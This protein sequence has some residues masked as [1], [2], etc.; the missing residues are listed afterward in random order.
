[1]AVPHL[2]FE[3]AGGF[4]H[5]HRPCVPGPYASPGASGGAPVDV[6]ASLDGIGGGLLSEDAAHVVEQPEDTSG[7]RRWM[8]ARCVCVCWWCAASCCG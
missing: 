7:D 6:Q 3:N 4:P 5:G 8:T 2:I 1:M